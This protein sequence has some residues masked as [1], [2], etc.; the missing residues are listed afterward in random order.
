MVRSVARSV[1]LLVLSL[2]L[3]LLDVACSDHLRSGVFDPPRTAP[4]FVLQGSDGSRLTLDRFR[5]K[6]VVLEFG[7]THCQ[8]ICP[9]TLANLA[10]VHK[11]L[12]A[13]AN[14][15]QVIFVT[16][17]PKRDSPERLRQYLG[18]FNPAFIGGTGTS[19]QLEV[20]SAEL[21]AVRQ[22]YGVVASEAPAEGESAYDIHHSSSIYLIDRD[23]KLRSLVPFGKPV[24]DIVHDVKLLLKS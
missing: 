19:D 16:V 11:H 24:D 7:F 15:V 17:D 4:N 18:I 6:V 3:G 22:A 14:E 2:V 10:Q 21:N 12:G 23:G 1:A 5:G 13:A 9:V 20:T 8:K